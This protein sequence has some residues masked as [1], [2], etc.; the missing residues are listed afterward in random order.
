[1]LCGITCGRSA[2]EA[3]VCHHGR[4]SGCS[5]AGAERWHRC[6][7]IGVSQPR[8]M[9]RVGSAPLAGGPELGGHSLSLHSCRRVPGRRSRAT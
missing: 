2:V 3:A 7:R 6:R 9:G 1:M 8:S 5:A 4:C